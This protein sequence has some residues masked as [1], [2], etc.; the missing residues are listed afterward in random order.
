MLQWRSGL[1]PLT[2]H[3]CNSGVLCTCPGA[4]QV[5]ADADKYM[6]ELEAEKEF[7]ELEAEQKKK[8]APAAAPAA[9]QGGQDPMQALEAGVG[10]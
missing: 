10:A 3:A 7:E 1:G 5:W 6:E 4:A 2:A 9:G 8:S